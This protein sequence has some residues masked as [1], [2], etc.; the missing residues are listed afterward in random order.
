M[1]GDDGVYNLIAS[2][3]ISIHALRVEGDCELRFNWSAELIISIHALRVEGDIV[4]G[5]AECCKGSDFYPRP[6]GGG[7]P[8]CFI[9]YRKVKIISIHALRVEGDN[10]T[11]KQ[12]FIHS[13]ISIHALR[14][15]GDLKLVDIPEANKISIHALRVEGDL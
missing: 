3:T 14:V 7:R 9:K 6:P 8:V 15:E 2:I 13:V 1:E 4:P 12:L 11:V 10:K 5:Q